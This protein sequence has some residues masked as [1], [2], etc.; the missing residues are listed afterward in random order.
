MQSRH[1]FFSSLKLGI[2]CPNFSAGNASDEPHSAASFSAKEI[3]GN[4]TFYDSPAEMLTPT[5]PGR[6]DSRNQGFYDE[7]DQELL[8]LN[9]DNTNTAEG[10][11]ASGEEISPEQASEDK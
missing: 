6:S 4:S 2:Q 9:Q 7:L 11:L 1:D 8:G 5:L 3:R 10:R